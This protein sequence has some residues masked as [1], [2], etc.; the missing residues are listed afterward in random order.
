M[1]VA[2]QQWPDD[3]TTGAGGHAGEPALASTT[4]QPEENLFSLIV[5]MMAQGQLGGPRFGHDFL[6]AVVAQCTRCHLQGTPMLLLPGGHIQMPHYNRQFQPIAKVLDK[7]GIRISFSTAESMVDMAHNQPHVVAAPQPVEKMAETER[8]RTSGDSDQDSI[9]RLEHSV[10][11]DGVVDFF[12]QHGHAKD[13]AKEGS[14][15][16]CLAAL[17]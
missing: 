17:L 9:A 6:E 2:F 15:G 8:V 13:L 7:T 14:S 5:G 3:S 11:N 12:Q 4:N 10:C 16:I 1:T